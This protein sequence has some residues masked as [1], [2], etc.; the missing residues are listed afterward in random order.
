MLVVFII[1][2]T[3]VSCAAQIQCPTNEYQIYN[4]QC[5]HSGSTGNW[6]HAQAYC[7]TFGLSVMGFR[8]IADMS[9]FLNTD[10][11]T[12]W[13]G[14]TDIANEGVFVWDDT[15]QPITVDFQ[16]IV[17]MSSNTDSNDCLIA[18]LGQTIQVYATDCVATVAGS[19]CMGELYSEGTTTPQDTTT[20]STTKRTKKP[21]KKG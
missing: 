17:D 16:N 12:I 5:Y 19:K 3:F 10:A 1:I 6:S 9:N 13:V 20:P 11:N 2:T 21:C 18:E 14:A 15:R 4:G 8:S 7:A